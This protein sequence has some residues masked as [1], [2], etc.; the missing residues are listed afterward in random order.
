MKCVRLA[1]SAIVCAIAFFVVIEPL[2]AAVLSESFETFPLAGWAIINN[3][4]PLNDPSSQ[5]SWF[6]GNSGIF[7]AHQGDTYAAANFNNAAPGSDSIISD[8]LITPTISLANGAVLN[9]YTR[10]DTASTF[11]DRL[12]VRLSTNGSSTDVGSTATS[13]GDFSMLLLSINPNLALGAYPEDWTLFTVTLSGL[14]DPTSGRLAFRYFVDNTND[15][16]N[17]IGIDDVSVSDNVSGVPLPVAGAGL[18]GLIAAVGGLFALVRRRR[19][20]AVA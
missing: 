12:E 4:A 11:P 14:P 5:T 15:N 18:P 13:V 16:A 9:F 10:T 7:Q 20:N 2:R 19:T 3:S 17:Y 6:Q 8:W 1:C